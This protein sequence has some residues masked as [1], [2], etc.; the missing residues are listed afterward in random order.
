[1]ASSVFLGFVLTLFTL[2]GDYQ[3]P[4]VKRT[5]IVLSLIRSGLSYAAFFSARFIRNGRMR[6]DPPPPQLIKKYPPPLG[7]KLTK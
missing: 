7:F 6:F 3:D 5:T 1:M 4:T 2:L